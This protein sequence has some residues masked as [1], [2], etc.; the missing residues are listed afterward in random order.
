MDRLTNHCKQYNLAHS[1]LCSYSNERGVAVVNI[2][3]LQF[4]FEDI[5]GQKR[6]LGPF[7][8]TGKKFRTVPEIL[9]HLATYGIMTTIIAIMSS[10]W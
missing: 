4:I 2:V 7:W 6:F 10:Y 5:S 1:L 8:D 9:G 3:G